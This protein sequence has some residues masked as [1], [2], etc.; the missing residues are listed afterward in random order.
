MDVDL[1]VV[2]LLVA[3]VIA[4]ITSAQPG[5]LANPFPALET[6]SFSIDFATALYQSTDPLPAVAS[7]LPIAPPSIWFEFTESQV[8]DLTTLSSLFTYGAVIEVYT[9][10]HGATKNTLT[11]IATDAHSPLDLGAVALAIELGNSVVAAVPVDLGDVAI[12][13]EPSD[14]V[15]LS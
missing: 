3:A 8:G 12:A 13:A 11:F 2:E 10:E 1:G 14:V 15:V 7:G 6:D 9:G 5:T 4:P